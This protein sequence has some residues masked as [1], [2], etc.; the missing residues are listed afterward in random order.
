M[1]GWV[2]GGGRVRVPMCLCDAARPKSTDQ[3][4][5]HRKLVSRIVYGYKLSSFLKL[6]SSRAAC[7]ELTGIARSVVT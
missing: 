7:G 5:R 4:K 3:Q 1:K 2:R 6:P